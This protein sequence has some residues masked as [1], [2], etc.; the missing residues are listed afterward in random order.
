MY[1]NSISSVIMQILFQYMSRHEPITINMLLEAVP[2]VLE[3]D[4]LTLAALRL[5]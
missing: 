3:D 4:G 2:E 1:V 5:A